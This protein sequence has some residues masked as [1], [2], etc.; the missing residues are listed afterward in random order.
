MRAPLVLP[1]TLARLLRNTRDWDLV[2]A[3][4]PSLIGNLVVTV[5]RLFR[6]PVFLLIRGEKQRTMRLML[7]GKRWA[8][9]YVWGL[10][11]MEWPVRR[12]I[13]SG[14]PTFVAGQ[15][16]VERYA[17]S[18]AR[19]YALFPGVDRSFP[20]A[21]APRTLPA[22]AE[23]TTLV[24]IARLS[25]EKGVDDLIRAVAVLRDRGAPVR[26][27]VAGSGPEAERIDALVDGLG[28]GEL[29]ELR[30]FVPHGPRLIEILDQG[31]VFVLPSHSEGQPHALLEAM[32]RALPAIG[33]RVGGIPALLGDGAGILVEARHPEQIADA[34]QAL[35]ADPARAERMSA[36]ALEIARANA[37]DAVLRALWGHLCEI[38]P[39][40][41]S[42]AASA[43]GRRV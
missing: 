8:R 22:P 4:V 16:L 37:P 2:G 6:R 32:S 31:S 10:A 17:A 9:P 25:G 33:S 38:Y 24:T 42:P 30:G 34:V 11:A 39:Q 27:I 26:A 20:F 12:W 36:R 5:A 14:T 19:V 13:S 40:F 18:G 41:S 1:V 35:R 21:D 43:D 29:V 23:P 7:H 28:V 3:V 15:E